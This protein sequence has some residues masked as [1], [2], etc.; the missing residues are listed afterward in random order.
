MANTAAV[1]LPCRTKTRCTAYLDKNGRN[2]KPREKEIR[3][4]CE[5]VVLLLQT[6]FC[7]LCEKGCLSHIG[8]SVYDFWAGELLHMKRCEKVVSSSGFRI[9]RETDRSI[10]FLCLCITQAFFLICL[11]SEIV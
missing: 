2:W 7:W 9:E 11:G 5:V 10:F 3:F 4:L 8:L 6:M 1:S